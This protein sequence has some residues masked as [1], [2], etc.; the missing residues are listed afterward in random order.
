[1]QETVGIPPVT[2]SKVKLAHKTLV[3]SPPFPILTHMSPGI[4]Q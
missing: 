3:T 1:M 2:P 4:P